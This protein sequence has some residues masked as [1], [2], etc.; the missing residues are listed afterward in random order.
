MGLTNDSISESSVV[1]CF[2]AFANNAEPVCAGRGNCLGFLSAELLEIGCIKLVIV[3]FTGIV[4]CCLGAGGA[5]LGIA[6]ALLVVA[7]GW[8]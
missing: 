2:T 8:Y 4:N 7:A 1:C 3:G 6:C 5:T